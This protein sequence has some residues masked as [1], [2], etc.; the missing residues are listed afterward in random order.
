[1]DAQVGVR[2]S[3]V[4]VFDEPE[5]AQT[6]LEQLQAEGLGPDEVS[7]M[8]RDTN[9]EREEAEENRYSPVAGSAA[10]GAALG[11]LLGGLAGW[12]LAIGAVGIPG[13]GLVIGAGALATTIAGIALG[14]AAG[15]LAGALLGLGVPEEDARQYEGHLRAGRVLLTLHPAADFPIERATGIMDANGGYD[16]RVYD[17]PSALVPYSGSPGESSGDWTS[18]TAGAMSAD[19]GAL[20]AGAEGGYGDGLAVTDV[21]SQRLALNAEIEAEAARTFAPPAEPGAD[22]ADAQLPGSGDLTTATGVAGETDPDDP[23]N[24]DA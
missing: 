18:V 10:T 17:T 23:Q 4:G 9:A 6:A 3:V 14:A 1:M 12:A 21:D 11:G 2:R 16:V 19:T 8:M 15:G 20:G 5:Q 7:I 22:V 13:V 24:K